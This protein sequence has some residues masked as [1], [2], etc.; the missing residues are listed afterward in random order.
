[1]PTELVVT[2][3]GPVRG[4]RRGGVLHLGGVPYGQARRFEQCEPLA[5]PEP[6]DATRPGP[7]PPQPAGAL[8]LVPGMAAA[9][10]SEECLCAEVWTTSLDGRRPVLVW[11]PGGSFLVGGAALPTYAGARLA[12]EHDVVVIGVNYRLGVLG[13]LAAAG[14]PTNLGLRDLRAAL[15]WVRQLAPAVG[16]D[17]D[18]VVLM[19]ESAG[20]G[21]IVHLLAADPSLPVAAAILASGA[22]GATL[23][24]AAAEWV[25]ERVCE[26]AGVASAE[27]LRSLPLERLLAAQEAGVAAALAKVGMMPLHPWADGEL[28]TAAPAVAPLAPVPLVVSTTADEMELFREQVPDLPPEVAV[29]FL[30]R[31]AAVLGVDE[32]GA[33]AGLAA[34]DGDLV[35][36]V[37]DVDLHLP[38]ALLAR[39][40]AAPVYPC[41]FTWA[42][43]GRGACHA[44][45]LPFTFGTLDVAEWR[46][47]AGAHDPA[48]DTLSHRMRSAWAAF[49]HQARPACEPVGPWPA[50]ELVQLGRDIVVGD[51]RIAARMGEWLRSG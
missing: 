7:A 38:N 14:V 6:I 27:G 17:P 32:A 40:H 23:T 11:V 12:A 16:G 24:A 42:A 19:G 44:L 50:G 46:T 51:D 25:G 29:R 13:W 26:A 39:R 9:L 36:A 33:A 2:P 30:A 45:D 35:A 37:A 10:T 31:K 28:V 47:F 20:A 48:A 41:R 18:R 15:D 34:C 5:W 43:P 3:F 21:A 49:A 4:E 8:D 22:P 1:M